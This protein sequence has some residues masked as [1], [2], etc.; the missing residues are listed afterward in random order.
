MMIDKKMIKLIFVY[1]CLQISPT[2]LYQEGNIWLW[3]YRCGTYMTLLCKHLFQKLLSPVVIDVG[4]EVCGSVCFFFGFEG[5]N[6]IEENLVLVGVFFA[7]EVAHEGFVVFHI[8][9]LHI[10]VTRECWHKFP[11]Q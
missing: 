8:I 4:V 7:S 5:G 9:P 11:H 3:E 6:L 10:E 1:I 2:P